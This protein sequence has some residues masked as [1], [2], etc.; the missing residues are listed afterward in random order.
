VQAAHINERAALLLSL[1]M[2]FL[3]L[4]GD[5]IKGALLL[6]LLTTF[7]ILMKF[8]APQQSYTDTDTQHFKPTVYFPHI[9]AGIIYPYE[10]RPQPKLN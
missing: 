9:C 1:T 10:L 4:T 8:W 6:A 5:E 7:L 2:L 3:Q